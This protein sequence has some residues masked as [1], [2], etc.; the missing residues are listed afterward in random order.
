MLGPDVRVQDPANTAAGGGLTPG[1]G[2]NL[3][4]TNQVGLGYDSTPVLLLNFLVAG[5]NLTAAIQNTNWFSFDV[6]V[7]SNVTDLDLTSLSFKVSR[8]AS[9]TPRGYGVL[10][11]TPT[12]TDELVQPATDV[13][14]VRPEWDPQFIDLSAVGSLQNLSAGQQVTFTIPTYSPSTINSLEF[15][16]I[17][18][19]GVVS[20]P[21]LPDYAE[22]GAL[23]VR[24][25]ELPSD[26][27]LVEASTRPTG[28]P[29]IF[30]PTRTLEQMPAALLGLAD[31]AHSSYGGRL[32][33]QTN[34]TGFFYPLKIGDRWW[35]VDPEGYL[36]LHKGVAAISR[37]SSPGG[38]EALA[39]LFG[40]A[41]HWADETAALL[42]Q[43]GFNGAGAWS[44]TGLIRQA[45]KPL[46]YTI[47]KNFLRTFSATNSSPGYPQVFDPAFESFCQANAQ[48][49]AST[50]N[51]A[52]LLGY[53]SDNE[54]PFSASILTSW[55]ALSPGNSSYD[56]A[57]RWLR[58]RYGPQATAEQVTTQDR[59]DFLGHVWGRYYS[60]VR[61]AIKLHDPNHLYLGSRFY[62]SDKDRPEIFRE[63]G[64]HVD[65]LSV[66][67]YGQWTP[68]ID[69]IRMWEQES[70]K[71]VIITEYYVKGEDSGMPNN[72]GAGWVVRTQTDRGCFYQNFTLALLESKVCVG[73]HWFRYADND[74]DS[75]ADPSNIDSN[76]G[77]ASNRYQTYDDLLDAMLE[78]NERA[79]LL[80]DYFDG[81]FR[82]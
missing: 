29:W 23:F 10:V 78:F 5:T 28:Q 79:Y 68:D 66:N 16:D 34:A 57:W 49:F 80:T 74:P 7:G 73:W 14:T 6:T 39:D 75:G 51:D 69:R 30:Y 24:V 42:Q 65:V 32:T 47:I 76:K 33:H 82:P 13:A 81:V 15:D 59:Y 48:S 52:Y 67:H 20:P 26:P 9:S 19:R 54:L 43:S 27:I 1:A 41:E 8:G 36:F 70:G 2:L 22:A 53:F 25:R 61:Q 35:L 11:T 56:E 50:Q 31:C 63:V 18:L 45:P 44:E 3:F 46:V 71:P 21:P 40:T 72:T 17:S 58:E 12:T 4:N 64:P 37:V 55:L 62:S 38:E 60:V 77:V